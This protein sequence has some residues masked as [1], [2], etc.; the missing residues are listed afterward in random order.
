MPH[1][2]IYSTQD[3]AQSGPASQRPLAKGVPTAVWLFQKVGRYLW[4]SCN[5]SRSQGP[6][7]PKRSQKYHWDGL[8]LE[9]AGCY[10]TRSSCVPETSTTLLE[11]QYN[12]DQSKGCVILEGSIA[13]QM[14]MTINMKTKY[15]NNTLGQL[16]PWEIRDRQWWTLIW[17]TWTGS[18]CILLKW[19]GGH[20]LWGEP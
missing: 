16:C 7:P 13:I 15:A 1:V 11:Q 18:T 4:S 12:M 8:V 17:R 20:H 14:A 6:N 3:H 5:G 19:K 9:T 10:K 2:C